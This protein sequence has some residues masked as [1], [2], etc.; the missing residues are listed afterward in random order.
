MKKE[1]INI[2]DRKCIAYAGEEPDFL[3][4][5][6]VNEF[7]MNNL[8]LQVE[9][10]AKKTGKSLLFAAFEVKIW[11]EELTPWSAPAV[12]GNDKFGFGAAQTLDFVV[13]ELMPQLV[14]RYGIEPDTPAVLGGYS[15]AALF[16]LWSAYQTDCFYA[17]AAASPSVWFPKWMEY[18]DSLRPQTDIIYLSLGDKEE[19]AK[20]KTLASVGNCIRAQHEKFV[21]DGI[22][23][24]LEWNEGNHF[25]DSAKR[26]AKAFGWCINQL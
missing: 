20:N 3:L 19:K 4:I 2:A 23:T 22:T 5:Q 10:I 12:F 26:C 14:E 7:E 16:S 8:E 25:K 17:I 21:E 9:M 1:L 11:N 18:T 24:I 15:L 13:N 6:P